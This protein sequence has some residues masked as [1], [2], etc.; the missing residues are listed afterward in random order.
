[1]KQ[2]YRKS[3]LMNRMNKDVVKMLSSCTIC[4]AYQPPNQKGSWQL[5]EIPPRA[6]HT[7]W[8]DLIYLGEMGTQW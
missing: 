4:Q 7:I 1:M 5:Y 6:C 3:G 2:A 8:F